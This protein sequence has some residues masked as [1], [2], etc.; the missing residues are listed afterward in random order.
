MPKSP[1][2]SVEAPKGP[3]ARTAYD[4]S[5]LRLVAPGVLGG[6]VDDAP[7]QAFRKHGGNFAGGKP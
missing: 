4:Y 3:G 2:S 1:C 5:F 7:A 6:K